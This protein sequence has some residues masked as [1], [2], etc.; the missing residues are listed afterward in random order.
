M[1]QLNNQI[2]LSQIEI[3]ECIKSGN[4]HI[5]NVEDL[6]FYQLNSIDKN[7]TEI[8][9][10]INEQNQALSTIS[11]CITF[12]GRL[13]DLST[14]MSFSPKQLSPVF[15]KFNNDDKKK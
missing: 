11:L 8:G 13:T 3:L 4:F 5:K 15:D 10:E 12:N 1:N 2:P 14:I 7:I 6:S 9:F